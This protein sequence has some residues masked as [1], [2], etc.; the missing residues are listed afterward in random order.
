M[1]KLP[2]VI[3]IGYAERQS[4]TIHPQWHDIP[5]DQIVTDHK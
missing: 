2:V 4:P 5:L 3:G 1:P